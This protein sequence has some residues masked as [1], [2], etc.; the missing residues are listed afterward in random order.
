MDVDNRMVRRLQQRLESISPELVKQLCVATQQ[1]N[2]VVQQLLQ[3][4]WFLLEGMR[5]KSIRAKHA[6]KIETIL[7]NLQC[8]LYENWLWMSCLA[9]IC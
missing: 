5:V 3:E 2:T 7:I 1:T 4:R 8:T 6:S 9:R